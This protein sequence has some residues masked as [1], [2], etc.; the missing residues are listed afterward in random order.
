[1][2]INK[3]NDEISVSEQINVDDLKD[4]QGCGIQYHYL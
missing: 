1:M 2:K 4:Y 3:I